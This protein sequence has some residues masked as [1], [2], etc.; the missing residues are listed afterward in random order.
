[1][2]AVTSTLSLDDVLEQILDS[3]VQT[4]GAERTHAVVLTLATDGTL[5]NRVYARDGQMRPQWVEPLIRRVMHD[6]APAVVADAALD[7]G[8]G[9]ISR[10]GLRSV[11]CVPLFVGD[12]PPRGAL[13][14]VSATFAAFSS[15][16]ARH[17]AAFAAQLALPSAT[18]NCTAGCERQQQLLQAVLRDINDGLVV[19]DMSTMSCWQIR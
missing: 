16:D 4:F 13:T 19:L 6:Q 3:T 8:L 5:T 2:R 7:A 1:L 17:L 10:S 18:P 15:S 12:G 14:V 11:I 9:A